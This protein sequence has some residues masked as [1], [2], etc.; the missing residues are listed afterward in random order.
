LRA[1]DGALGSD[2]LKHKEETTMYR[3]IA[4]AVVT[5]LVLATTAS[6][7]VNTT[8]GFSAAEKSQFDRASNPNGNGY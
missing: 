4:A 5:A 6:A 2:P 3:K 1:S 8:R 7:A